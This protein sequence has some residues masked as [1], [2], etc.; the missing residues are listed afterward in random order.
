MPAPVTKVVYLPGHIPAFDINVKIL[1]VMHTMTNNTAVPA[2]QKA[3]IE[4]SRDNN[5]NLIWL[6]ISQFDWNPDGKST[7]KDMDEAVNAVLETNPHAYIVLNINIDPSR[8]L[9]MRKWFDLH[10]DQLIQKE[11]GSTAL[12][13]YG[14]VPNRGE[15]YASFASKIWMNDATQSWRELIRHVRSGPYADRVIG[16]VP[17]AGISAEW[18]YYGSQGKDFVDYSKPFT[19]AFANWMKAQ[20][21]GDLALL[22]KT[23]N[24]DYASF[25]AIKLPTEAQRRAPEDG[26]F[27]DP[28]KSGEVIDLREFFTQI[29]SGDILDFCHVVKEETNGTA[30]CGTYYGYVMH[31]GRAYFGVHSGH[32]A[33]DRMLA[34]PDID[35][36]MS[37][38]TYSDRGL[39][40]G[41]GFM[42]AVDS[43]KLHGKL[44]VDQADIRTLHATDPIGK[45]DTLTDSVSVLQREFANSVV[46]GVA[47][48][49]FD[50]G[51]GW[52]AGDARL[53]QAV[54][55]M[56]QI[57]KTLQQTPRE[58]IDAPNSI[59]VITG[60]KSILYTK[61][62]SNLNYAA[63][64][65]QI[66]ELQRT[67]AAWDNYLLD[68]L[69]K[70]GKYHYFVFL[71]CFNLSD[72]QLKYIN[73][74]LKKDGNVLVWINSPGVIDNSKSTFAQATYDPER[75][76]KVTGFQLKHIADGP[77][78]TQMLAGNNPLQQDGAIFGSSQLSGTRFAP[79]D[80][81][82]LGQFPDDQQ[83]SL[84]IKKFADWTSI[85]SATPTLPAA[86][87]RNIA[88]LANV[89]V[90]NNHVGDITYV[91]K[92]LFAVHSLG[93]GERVFH[94]GDGYKNAKE[95]FSDQTYAV[96]NGKFT[97]TVPQ[98]GTMLFLLVN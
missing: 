32:F 27:L 13:G 83:T 31:I 3:I 48:Q 10:P 45:V 91:S 71:N 65:Q 69:P 14:G 55:K 79:Q 34:S 64:S 75:V 95:L 50:F 88:K 74:N 84:A 47:P 42:T 89:P 24:T 20:Y 44:Y 72:A 33:L 12:S 97:A 78:V 17:I 63:T 43:F 53:M 49:W 9:G 38:S 5:V 26:V 60:E 58:T 37:P 66:A 39:G 98:G 77:L 56:W 52:I 92:N 21:N 29:I 30:I 15:K 70:L 80:G 7:F 51:D 28:A 46:N 23:W 41:S 35:F 81:V 68:D 22:N 18:F 8:N 90:I 87:L 59:A 4:N 62:D 2:M 96:Q 11:D 82:A 19:A 25:D 61:V 67:G 76:S 86:L 36:L 54:G 1:P 93:G 40:G 57:A 73:E 85:Y 94:V 6:N 16:Y